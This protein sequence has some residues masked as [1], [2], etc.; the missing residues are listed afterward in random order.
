MRGARL[1]ALQA[2]LVKAASEEGFRRTLSFHHQIREAE[3]FAAGLP[4]IAAQLHD[5]ERWVSLGWTRRGS[6]RAGQ[7]REPARDR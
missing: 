5:S 1:A 3:A 2:A 4:D 7:R 6:D